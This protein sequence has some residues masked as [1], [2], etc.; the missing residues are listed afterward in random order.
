MDA[1]LVVLKNKSPK[2][3]E[4]ANAYVLNFNGRVTQPSVKNFQIVSEPS[5]PLSHARHTQARI[6]CR[7]R[8]QAC[9]RSLADCA[10]V[11][12]CACAPPVQVD[13]KDSEEVVIMQFGR[14]GDNDFTCDFQY[15]LSPLQAFGIA[16]SSFDYK[17]ACE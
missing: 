2:W 11:P 16:L 3:N 6:A 12:V 13:E 17:I 9:L 10:R 14:I 15:P 4:V 5:A 8:A 1:D 7:G